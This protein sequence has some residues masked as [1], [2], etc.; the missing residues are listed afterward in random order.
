MHLDIILTQPL[1][2]H[3]RS[4]MHLDIIITQPLLAHTRS[5]IYL[6]MVLTSPLLVLIIGC[7]SSYGSN[8]SPLGSYY[9]VTF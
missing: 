6:N 7:L 4:D 8:E 3:T 1:L 2:A 9:R 5:D